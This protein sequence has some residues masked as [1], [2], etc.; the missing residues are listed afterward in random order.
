MGI[1]PGDLDMLKLMYPNFAA[2]AAGDPP[3][4]GAPV[5]AFD[6]FCFDRKTLLLPPPYSCCCS[7]SS[8][9]SSC[10]CCCWDRIPVRKLSNTYRETHD[11]QERGGPPEEGT[12]GL[13]APQKKYRDPTALFYTV[14][15]AD[16]PYPSGAPGGPPGAP[17]GPPGASRGP[18]G[19]PWGTP[20]ASWGPP[21]GPS[22]PP[23][24]M[25][26]GRPPAPVPPYLVDSSEGWGPPPTSTLGAPTGAPTGALKGAP[27]G[28]PMG[29]PVKAPQRVRFA[30]S[31]SSAGTYGENSW[32]APSGGPT[33]GAPSAAPWGAP[34]GPPPAGGP[35]LR[36]S[37]KPRRI[38]AP[39]V[40]R[41]HN[42]RHLH[43]IDLDAFEDSSL[44]VG[45]GAPL[46]GPQGA[47]LGAP[48]GGPPGAPRGRGYLRGV[49]L[50]GCSSTPLRLRRC[51]WNEAEIVA[52]A[53]AP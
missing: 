16:Q 17:W 9:S 7:S 5:A 10:C 32:G 19:A 18:A 42:G 26:N 39:F 28:A 25:P 23:T 43:L 13:G 2:A 15:S 41:A 31:S 51:G 52:E 24:E 35:P 33:V 1:V 12:A 37:L 14:P 34:W 46:G 44:C 38:T 3:Q 45:R 53:A 6:A 11:F 22:G 21:G 30:E 48:L 4:R 47:P 40:C 20:G 50:P 29:A 49:H 8:S 36:P 27:T